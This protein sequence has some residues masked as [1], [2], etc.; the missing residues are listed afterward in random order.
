MHALGP[1]RVDSDG[2]DQRRVDAAGEAQKNLLE[3][4][5]LSYELGM[6]VNDANS[7]GVTALMGAAN[8]GSDEIIQWLVDKGAKLDVKDAEALKNR[9]N[10]DQ[11]LALSGML[12]P[13]YYASQTK[14][15]DAIKWVGRVVAIIMAIG[16]CFA[17]MNTM[18]AAVSRRRT[19]VRAGCGI[20]AG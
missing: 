19:Q 20:R 14:S 15:G 18:Y 13:E 2:G 8:R 11:R 4:V 6:S 7:M 1:Q 17:A 9:A 16:S 12:E 5:K 3:A 10:D